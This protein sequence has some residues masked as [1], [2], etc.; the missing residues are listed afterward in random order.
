MRDTGDAGRDGAP[1][2]P[3]EP[4][5]VI[6][7]SHGFF[8]APCKGLS[9]NPRIENSGVLVIPMITAPAFFKLAVTGESPGAMLSLKASDAVGVGLALDV[10]VDLDGNRHAVKDAQ[11]LAARLSAIHRPRRFDRL[12]ARDRPRRH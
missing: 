10:D 1:A 6:A 5:Q 4:P 12:G 3:D 7:L 8:V 9:V 2:P 11:R